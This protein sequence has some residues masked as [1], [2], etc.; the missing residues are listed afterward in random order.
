MGNIP[1]PIVVDFDISENKVIVPVELE[2]S[3]TEVGLDVALDIRTVSV[4]DYD[5][6]YIVIPK[7]FQ[8]QVLLTKGKAMI[9]DVTVREIPYYETSNEHGG[10][11]VN[12]GG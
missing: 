7:A 5:G 10:Y 4:E 12:I 11:T 6:D 3:N 1:N 9:D 2:A 8:E